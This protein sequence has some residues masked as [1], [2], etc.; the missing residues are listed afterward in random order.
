MTQRTPLGIVVNPN[1]DLQSNPFGVLDF[2]GQPSEVHRNMNSVHRHPIVYRLNVF[3]GLPTCCDADAPMAQRFCG[4]NELE[5][6]NGVCRKRVVKINR[7]QH[8]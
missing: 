8:C 5:P 3:L 7:N 2:A 1:I 4:L 6:Q